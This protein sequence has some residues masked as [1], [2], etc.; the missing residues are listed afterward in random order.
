MNQ[1]KEKNIPLHVAIILDGNRRWAK[2]KGFGASYGHIKSS[3]YEQLKSLFSEAKKLGVKYLSLWAFSTENWLR[4]E[5][6]REVIFKLILDLVIKCRKDCSENKI[7][8]IHIGRKDRLPKKPISEISK[9]E[10]K[11]KNFKDFTIILC[12]DYGGRDEI[13]RAI[14]KIIKLKLKKIDEQKFSRLLDTSGIPDV[15]L[16]IRTAGERRASGF[17]PF[18]SVYSEFYFSKLCFPDFDRKELRKAVKDFE[19]RKRN[20]GK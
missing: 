17:M 14:N 20:F 7:K 10:K 16:I 15:D 9:L 3:N 19:K 2:S 13:L 5:K 11:T 12:L 8:F 1:T 18:Q 6:E 4:P